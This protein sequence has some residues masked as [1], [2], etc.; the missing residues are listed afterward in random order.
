MKILVKPTYYILYNIYYILYNIYR[1]IKSY[2]YGGV[3]Q[4]SDNKEYKLYY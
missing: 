4:E 2:C 3:T 1:V